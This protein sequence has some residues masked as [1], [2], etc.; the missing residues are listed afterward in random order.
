MSIDGKLLARAVGITVGR[1]L[2]GQVATT[3]VATINNI[4]FLFSPLLVRASSLYKLF[5]SC[6]SFFLSVSQFFCPKKFSATSKQGRRLCFGTLTFL[7]NI[8]STKVLHH[9]SCIIPLLS[10]VGG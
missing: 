9:A 4:I 7:T 6:V 10:K 2:G 3:L 8:R 5:C 1:C